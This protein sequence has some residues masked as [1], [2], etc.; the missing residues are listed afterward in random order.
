MASFQDI[1]DNIAKVVGGTQP[2]PIQRPRFFSG[3]QVAD[4]TGLQPGAG[5]PTFKGCY[6]V[7]EDTIPEVPMGIVLPGPFEISGGKSR[8]VYTQGVEINTD[9]LRLLILIAR[10]DA[11]TTYQNLMPYRDIVP[12]TFAA[13]MTAFSS[14]NVLQAMV[15][16]GKPITVN[17]AGVAYDGME[18]TI[19]V[20]RLIPRTYV[21]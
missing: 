19:R 16:G 10:Q 17:W 5:Y 4:G 20:I 18:F 14:A 8:D 13:K 15:R 3:D 6:S 11:E 1:A 2:D 9:D 12:A 21:A 7:P